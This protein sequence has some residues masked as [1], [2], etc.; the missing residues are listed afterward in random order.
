MPFRNIRVIDC[1]GH[2]VG[3]L[4]SV[5]AKE[6][7]MGQRVACVRCEG[8][9][10]SG[11]YLRNKLKFE[12]FLQKKVNTNPRRG[13][14]HERAPS[15]IFWR[16]VR[17]MLPHKTGRGAQ[18]LRRLSVCEGI[19]PRYTHIRRSV[20]P[21]AMRVLRLRPDRAFTNLA[22]ISTEFGWHYAP[23]VEKLEAKRK[24]GGAVHHH[25]VVKCSL[26]RDSI[27]SKIFESRKHLAKWQPL[28]QQ[29]GY[30]K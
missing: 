11:S 24:V 8:L 5:V 26:L 10:M 25:R 4:A 20:V 27:K 23:I 6:L 2:L 9:Q 17:G 28:L 12:S 30:A 16:A 18:A 15:R 21:G 29:F 14:F 13:P 22:E 19:P 1:R 7:L 3:R